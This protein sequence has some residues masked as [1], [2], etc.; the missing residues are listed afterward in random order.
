M[1]CGVDACFVNT[2]DQLFA[3]APVGSWSFHGARR[4]FRVDDSHWR[5][6]SVRPEWAITSGLPTTRLS[7]RVT[8]CVA[9]AARSKSNAIPPTMG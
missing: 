6:N 5:C 3:L 2:F 7:Q 4:R 8:W 9:R 1:F